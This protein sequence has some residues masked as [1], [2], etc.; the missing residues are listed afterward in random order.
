M[1]A[2]EACFIIGGETSHHD[3]FHGTKRSLVRSILEEGFRI[4]VNDYDWLGKGVYF[5]QDAP[6]RALTWARERF[7]TETAVIGADI[8]LSDCIDLLD[9]G[10]TE[11]FADVYHR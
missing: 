9:T 7:E 6:R 3:R 10:W 8:D 11:F 4:S 2:K 5:F 1:P